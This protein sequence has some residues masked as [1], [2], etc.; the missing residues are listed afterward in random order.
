MDSSI[1]FATLLEGVYCEI[2]VSLECPFYLN[3][4]VG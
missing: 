3:F 4:N 2:T 1:V